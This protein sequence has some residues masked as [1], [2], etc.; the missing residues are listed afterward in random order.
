MQKVLR[1]LNPLRALAVTGFRQSFP[2]R[3]REKSPGFCSLRYVIVSYCV[4]QTNNLLVY[5]IEYLKNT[6]PAKDSFVSFAPDDVKK[7][8][9]DPL[10]FV[11][12]GM[13]V[14]FRPDDHQDVLSAI[15]LECDGI[16]R[17]W[18]AEMV[19][20]FNLSNKS[21]CV[22]IPTGHF[23]GVQDPASRVSVFS[24]TPAPNSST[25]L[26]DLVG[27]ECATAHL[28]MGLR[29]CYY[30]YNDILA[31]V[32]GQQEELLVK[33]FA[34]A[35]SGLLVTELSIHSFLASKLP[36]SHVVLDMQLLDLYGEVH[37]IK[38]EGIIGK[39]KILLSE[40]SWRSARFHTRGYLERATRHRSPG[41]R[42]SVV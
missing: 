10:T 4:L 35:A 16:R 40:E 7:Q 2:L 5:Q 26:D 32:G 28:I 19:Y 41:T 36:A 37:E 29:W 17:V 30:M 25:E 8:R 11:K 9:V 38:E 3:L 42:A 15:V 6:H 13:C 39:L 33:Q 27:K 24:R 31:G 22:D 1:F 21:A 20:P 18:K 14:A 23:L 34:E 12:P